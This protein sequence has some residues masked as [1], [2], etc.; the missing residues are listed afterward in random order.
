MSLQFF[1]S[2]RNDIAVVSF[3]GEMNLATLGVIDDCRVKLEPLPCRHLILNLTE[4]KKI[5]EEA[6]R[7]IA[8]IQN[9]ARKAGLSLR[10]CGLREEL[11]RFLL[12]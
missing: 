6:I 3:A 10:I 11:V 5:S 7:P 1:V 12:N 2:H 4:V 8:L 9:L